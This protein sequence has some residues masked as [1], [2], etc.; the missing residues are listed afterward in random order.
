MKKSQKLLVTVENL[1]FVCT[2]DGIDKNLLVIVGKLE[3]EG[4]QW[5]PASGLVGGL[6]VTVTYADGIK[7]PTKQKIFGYDS[8]EFLQKQY[9]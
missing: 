3:K 7:P 2:L 5:G 4:N 8:D 6:C 1:S 9:K